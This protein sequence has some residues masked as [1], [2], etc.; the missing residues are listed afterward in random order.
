MGNDNHVQFRSYIKNLKQNMSPQYKDY[1]YIGRIEKFISYVSVQRSVTFD[2]EVLALNPADLPAVWKR[3]NYLTGMVFPYG[4]NKG[5]LQPNIIRFT[6]GRI[7]V[8]Q[9]GYVESMDVSFM[10]EDVTGGIFDLDEQV[11]Q[12][13]KVTMKFNLIE[14]R[15]GLANTPFF[16]ITQG[17]SIGPAAPTTNPVT[18][19]EAATNPPAAAGTPPAAATP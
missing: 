4:V 10:G 14:K 5:I 19:T 3:I 12:G 17:Y 16:G 13:A 7:F 11:T 9:P 2:L 6:I 8:D 1:Q 15:T 18:G